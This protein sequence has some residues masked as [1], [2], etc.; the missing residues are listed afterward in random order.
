MLDPTAITSASSPPVVAQRINEISQ[1]I[2]DAEKLFTTVAAFITVG[3]GGMWIA[4]RKV[5]SQIRGIQGTVGGIETAVEPVRHEITDRADDTLSSR[6][7]I[8]SA[9]L[10]AEKQARDEQHQDNTGRLD[11]IESTMDR[12]Q[13]DV[14]GIRRVLDR[15]LSKMAQI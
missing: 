11:R 12:L 13:E 2:G 9:T 6:V 1:Y 4:L 10:E 3:V 14:A 15:I 5:F 7:D 8:I